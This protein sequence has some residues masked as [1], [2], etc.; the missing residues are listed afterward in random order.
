MLLHDLC[1]DALRL[2]EGRRSRSTIPSSK[3]GGKAIL[4][5]KAVSAEDQP[6]KR[7]RIPIVLEFGSGQPAVHWVELTQPS[8]EFSFELPGKP[9]KVKVDPARNFLAQ[10]K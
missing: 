9:T 1:G 10:F 2:G 4:A 5:G 6:F 8:T 7:M 3:R